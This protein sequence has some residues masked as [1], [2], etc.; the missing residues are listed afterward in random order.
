M[1]QTSPIANSNLS[2]KELQDKYIFEGELPHSN[3]RL[4][5]TR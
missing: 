4:L 3:C 5:R 1:G 2:L